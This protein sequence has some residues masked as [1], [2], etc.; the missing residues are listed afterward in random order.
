[1]K[2]APEG[3]YIQNGQQSLFT[4]GVEFGLVSNSSRDL[5]AVNQKLL[6]AFAQGNPN[7]R[8]AGSAREWQLSGRRAIT[9]PLSNRSEATGETESIT[10]T[11][12]LLSDGNLFYLL[13][14]A[15]EREAGRYS[16]AFNRVL[17]SVKLR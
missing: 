1:V 4:H 11:T 6:N 2:Y 15:P 8:S 14:V 9:T 3:G 10:V 17:Q 16:N 5:R 12:A 13:T 7:L